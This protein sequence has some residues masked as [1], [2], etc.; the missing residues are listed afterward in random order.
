MGNQPSPRFRILADEVNVSFVM[1][2]LR[3]QTPKPPH[4]WESSTYRV[5]AVYGANASGKSTLLEAV[6]TLSLAVATPGTLLYQPHAR[7]AADIPT[8]YD[9]NFTSSGI[10]YHY[11]VEAMPWGIGVERLHAY[12]KGVSRLLFHRTQ[13]G[14]DAPINVATGPSLTGPTAEVKRLVTSTDLLL[15]V[16]A[17]YEHKT[18]APISRDMAAGASVGAVNHSE[19]SLDDWVQW[20]VSRMIEN[21]TRWQAIAKALANMADLGIINVEVQEEQIPPEVLARMRAVLAAGVGDAS[22]Q[23]P[24]DALPAVIR[25]LVFT[26]LAEDGGSFHLGL[27]AQS[28][29]TL[30]WLMTAGTAV[31]AIARGGILI[32]DELDASLHPSLAAAIVTMFKDPDIN[33]TGA[34]VLFSTHDTSLLGNAPNKILDPGENWFCEK[35]GAA[36]DVFPLADF[37]TRASNNEQ[38]RYL[39]GRFGAL[40][41]VDFSRITA[42]LDLARRPA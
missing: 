1:P 12:P 38:K 41:D 42:V 39:T 29:G 15:A 34:Q 28:S 31:E 27:G 10:R 8:T 13:Q 32:V 5:A 17:R 22:T 24:D 20:L 19:K 7:A 4:T 21:P 14:P 26:H 16:A 9:S 18:L 40:P 11:T 6:K 2:S 30:T 37:D 35:R 23:I 33:T 3:T 25:S 36:S